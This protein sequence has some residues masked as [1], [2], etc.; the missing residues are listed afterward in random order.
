[1]CISCGCEIM[2]NIKW[3]NY[4]MITGGSRTLQNHFGGFNLSI[5]RILW[6]HKNI[7]E[8]LMREFYCHSSWI[9]M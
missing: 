4:K 2:W 7:L 9:F 3:W 6:L 1:M 8:N 5:K